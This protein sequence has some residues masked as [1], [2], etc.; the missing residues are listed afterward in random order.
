[1]KK[2]FAL[3]ALFAAFSASAGIVLSEDDTLTYQEPDG[4][5]LSED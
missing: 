5:V 2:L 3:F 1:M 4:L